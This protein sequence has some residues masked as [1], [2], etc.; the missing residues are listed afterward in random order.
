MQQA[1]KNADFV[2]DDRIR[3]ELSCANELAEAVR[4]HQAMVQRETLAT[5]F[6]LTEAP[7]GK[8]VESVDLEEGPVRI[9]VT[10]L[11]RNRS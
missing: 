10:P 3:L 4:A 7:Q 8:H 11:T 5:E 6:H 2:L 1:R 9:G